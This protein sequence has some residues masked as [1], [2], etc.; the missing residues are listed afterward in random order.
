MN[1]SIILAHPS[2]ESFNHA[3]ARVCRKTL[4]ELGHTVKM[5]DLYK[6][7]FNPVLPAEEIPRDGKVN[8]KVDAYCKEISHCDGII[9][10]HPNWWGQPPAILKGWI[11][12][13][14]RPGVAYEFREGDQGEGVPVGMLE[15]KAGIVFNTSDTSKEREENIFLDPLETIWKNCIF[16]LCG[17]KNYYRKMFRIVVTSTDEERKLWLREVRETI[18]RYFPAHND[19]DPE[20]E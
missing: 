13:V 15:A 14:F 17:I 4:R 9:I 5:H 18:I 10:I 8:K 2:K 1:I 3:I 6:E 7:K 20:S 19:H 11:D 16:Y 12:R